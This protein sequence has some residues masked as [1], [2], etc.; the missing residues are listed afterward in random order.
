MIWMEKIGKNLYSCVA[1][2]SKSFYMHFQLQCKP[3]RHYY[4]L[5]L[6]KKLLLD[7]CIFCIM[8][9]CVCAHAATACMSLNVQIQIVFIPCIIYVSFPSPPPP[10]PSPPPPPPPLSS[11][12]LVLW[13]PLWTNASR[14]WCSKVLYMSY[15]LISCLWNSEEPRFVWIRKGH[16]L[17]KLIGRGL[18]LVMWIHCY[19]NL[20]VD[21]CHEFIED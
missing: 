14:H 7:T 11:H 3:L 4:E 19:F 15:V 16:P 18:F 8:I 6:I 5:A 12:R 9:V 13:Y 1:M 10:T 2:T 21:A 17:I 20:L